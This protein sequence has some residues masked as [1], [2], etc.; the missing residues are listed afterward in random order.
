VREKQKR[1]DGEKEKLKTL[2]LKVQFDLLSVSVK[3]EPITHAFQSLL[4]LCV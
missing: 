4:P 2:K 1:A 3:S